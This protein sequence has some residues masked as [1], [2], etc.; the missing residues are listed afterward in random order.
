MRMIEVSADLHQKFRHILRGLPDDKSVAVIC[1]PLGRTGIF[2]QDA[3][4]SAGCRLAH[5]KAI[6]VESGRE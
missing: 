2:D 1:D 3:C 6:G 4:Q 5:D